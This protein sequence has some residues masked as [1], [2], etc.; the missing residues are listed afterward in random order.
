M[1]FTTLHLIAKDSTGKESKKTI[2]SN[3]AYAVASLVEKLIAK[4]EHARSS[5]MK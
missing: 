3:D 4:I 5:L 1:D 2:I